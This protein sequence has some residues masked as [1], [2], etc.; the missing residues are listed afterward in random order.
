VSVRGLASS[1]QAGAL[2]EPLGAGAPTGVLAEA[3]ADAMAGKAAS[4][5]ASSEARAVPAQ[6]GGALDRLPRGATV[7]LKR[8]YA[9]RSSAEHTSL[10]QGSA[11]PLLLPI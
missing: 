11:Y 1:Q 5:E 7:R 8:T 3:P 6:S 10:L 9:R 2:G 4:E